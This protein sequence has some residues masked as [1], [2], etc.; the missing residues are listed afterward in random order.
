VNSER[1]DKVLIEVIDL[2][3]N[4]LGLNVGTQKKIETVITMQELREYM[5]DESFEIKELWFDFDDNHSG[6]K[7]RILFNFLYNKLIMYD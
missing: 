7:I 2:Q 6:P 4:V 5:E 1:D 3:T